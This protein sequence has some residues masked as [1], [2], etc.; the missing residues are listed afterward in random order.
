[1]ETNKQKFSFLQH[2]YFFGL[3][4]PELFWP[5][6]ERQV[7]NNSCQLFGSLLSVLTA[8]I[9]LPNKYLRGDYS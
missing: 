8:S 5:V 2:F 3:R 6:E 4:V 7:N 9:K 1:M